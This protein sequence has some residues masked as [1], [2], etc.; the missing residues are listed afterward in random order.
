MISSQNS[1][2]G[3]GCPSLNLGRRKFSHLIGTA[4]G[5]RER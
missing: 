2:S 5:L 1:D 3:E 4:I